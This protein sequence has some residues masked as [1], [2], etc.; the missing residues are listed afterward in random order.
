MDDKLQAKLK[1]VDEKI[2]GFATNEAIDILKELVAAYP[3]EGIIPY[4]FGKI[5]LMA[6]EN[7][8]ALNYFNAAIRLNY[9]LPDVYLSIA[10]LQ[11]EM[12]LINDAEKSFLK[13]SEQTEDKEL[14]WASLSCL[15]V[16]YIE[17]EMYLKAGK[18]SKTMVKE[19]PNNYQGYHL[20]FTI[21][22]M[23]KGYDDA[24]SYLER[25]PEQFKNHPQYLIDLVELYKKSGKE[26]KLKDLFETDER[27][28][29]FIPQIVLREKI[30]SLSDSNEEKEAL[31]RKLAKEHSDKDAILSLMIL[32]FSRKNFEK[33]AK[34]ANVI[35]DKEKSNQGYRYYLAL[36][37]QMY[38]FYYLSEKKPSQELMNWIEKAGNWCINFADTFNIPEMGKTVRD[39]VNELFD[40]INNGLKA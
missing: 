25:L 37:F 11:K 12:G 33:S 31:I 35:L 27:F 36:Y 10:L 8:M 13:A 29:M 38:N 16:F 40:E 34:I 1:D 14:L 18:I 20:H 28:K 9:N 39:S 4:Y 6:K 21:E 19:F 23:R 32:E 7:E 26:E 15:A 22:T 5:C 30:A 2:S 24:F 17:N 3:D